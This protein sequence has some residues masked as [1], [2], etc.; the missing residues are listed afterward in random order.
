MKETE[1]GS[2]FRSEPWH[3]VRQLANNCSGLEQSGASGSNAGNVIGHHYRK[4]W[5]HT[6]HQCVLSSTCTLYFDKLASKGLIAA[7]SELGVHF[8][9]FHNIMQYCSMSTKKMFRDENQHVEIA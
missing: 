2:L 7:G 3:L 6:V 4:W 5:K 1:E 8:I 9:V